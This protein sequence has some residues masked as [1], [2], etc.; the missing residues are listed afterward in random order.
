MQ[1]IQDY[2]DNGFLRLPAEVSLPPN[3]RLLILAVNE[4]E[5]S[6]NPDS[7]DVSRLIEG[8]GYFNSVSVTPLHCHDSPL[9]RGQ[10]L[11]EAWKQGWV[12]DW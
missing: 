2:V 10:L 1:A 12:Q 9:G 5:L 7:R 8:C 11:R 6:N 4:D 3:T